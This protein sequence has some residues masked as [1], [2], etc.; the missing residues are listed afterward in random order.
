MLKLENGI[1][2][3]LKYGVNISGTEHPAPVSEMEIIDMNNSESKKLPV[4]LYFEL[5]SL[6]GGD[7]YQDWR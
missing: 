2:K 3:N 7:S 5:T 4:V 1:F 6:G